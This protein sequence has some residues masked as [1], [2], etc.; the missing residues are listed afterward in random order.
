MKSAY[1]SNPLLERPALG[2]ARMGGQRSPQERAF[3]R[4]GTTPALEAPPTPV[5]PTPPPTSPTRRVSIAPDA[6]GYLLALAAGVLW[7]L[8]GPLS[9]ALF[10]RGVPPTS[11]A[12]LRPLVG[13]AILA[14]LL[15]FQGGRHFR[16]PPRYLPALLL[17]G[18]AIVALFQLAY[19]RSTDAVG[20]PSTVALLYLAPGM[21]VLASP[22]VVGERLTAG[23]FLLALISAVGVW[24]AVSGAHGEVL[25]SEGGGLGWGMAAA[26]GF[27]SYTLFARR[28]APLTGA[29]SALF[30]STLGGS[31]ILGGW[32]LGTGMEVVLPTSPEAWGLTVALGS[33]TL[34]LA[35]FLY[36]QALTS[37]EA[38]RAAIVSTVE[39]VV[40]TL[41]AIVFLGQGLNG[42][43]WLGLGLMLVGVV[44]AYGVNPEGE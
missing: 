13:L 27:A 42:L 25:Q 11:V 22:W 15:T 17:V 2:Q 29:L 9:T 44:G 4:R 40:A 19:Q 32:L 14:A 37:I 3:V 1:F 21:V 34:A 23:K 24:L 43:G 16:V 18:G 28:L 5:M 8:S 20:V 35:P 33:L 31:V 7:A 36:F 30:Y 41:L 6:M 26:A 10:V 12:L 38:G 39:P